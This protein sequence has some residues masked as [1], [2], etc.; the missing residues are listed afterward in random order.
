MGHLA[1]VTGLLGWAR[2]G[3]SSPAPSV[4]KHAV[5]RRW[6][7]GLTGIWVESGTYYGHTAS[8]LS[9][10][11]SRVVTI[12]PDQSL[13]S[14]AAQKFSGT[15][16]E[17]LNGLSEN[18]MA[19]VLSNLSVV[20]GPPVFLWLDGHFSGG[21]THQG[22]SDTPVLAELEQIALH[23]ANVKTVFID[24][25]RCFSSQDPEYDDY[26]SRQVLVRWAEENEYWWTV[27]HD[28]FIAYRT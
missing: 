11:A 20:N 25:F 15:N 23:G 19:G 6:S 3:F 9:Q 22:P 18:L 27:E 8:F 1:N 13:F 26:P 12:E 17:V 4:V 24:D 28:I 10:I 7:F 5:L 2:R 21:I 14:Q 16:V